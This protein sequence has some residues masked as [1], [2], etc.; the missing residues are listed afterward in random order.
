[1][2]GDATDVSGRT[3]RQKCRD[4]GDGYGASCSRRSSLLS[5]GNGNQTIGTNGGRSV[6]LLLLLRMQHHTVLVILVATGASVS[7]WSALAAHTVPV[8]LRHVVTF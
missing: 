6:M 7:D 5:A 2:L 1:M 8:R 3:G 4:G